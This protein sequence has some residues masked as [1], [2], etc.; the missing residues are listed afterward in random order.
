MNPAPSTKSCVNED[1]LVRWE[2]H[3]T[4]VCCPMRVDEETVAYLNHAYAKASA[5]KA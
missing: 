4:G 2:V 3:L 1:H 5:Y